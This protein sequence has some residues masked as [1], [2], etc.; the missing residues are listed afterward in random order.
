MTGAGRPVA[1]V[2]EVTASFVSC[3][4]ARPVMPPL[5][6]GLARLQHAAY[7]AAL[8]AGGF[9]VFRAPPALEHPDSPFI[10]DTAVVIGDRA[11]VTHPGHPSRRGEVAGVVAALAPW[12]EVAVMTEGTLDGGDV[13]QAGGKVFVGASLRTD[14]AGIAALA[15]FCAPQEVVPVSVRATLH[16]KSGVSALDSDTVL[17]H[18]AA[19]DRDALGGVLVVE[20]PGDDPEAANVVRLPDGSILVSRH[21]RTTADLVGSLEFPVRQVDV[22]EFARADGGLT[23]LSLRLRSVSAVSSDT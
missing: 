17:W 8:E 7:V 14:P 19:C 9:A 2:R 12:V 23:C 16:L 6:P 11:L 22:S 21:H 20:V 5:D 13:L 4:T 3:V 15:R 1:L 10:E 18:P